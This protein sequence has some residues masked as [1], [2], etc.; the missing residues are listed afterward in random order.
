MGKLRRWIIGTVSGLA[1]GAAALLYRSCGG[2]GVVHSWKN[3]TESYALNTLVAREAARLSPDSQAGDADGDGIPNTFQDYITLVQRGK[4]NKNGS[5]QDDES[6]GD[7]FEDYCRQ[8]IG[9]VDESLVRLDIFSPV[10]GGRSDIS[11][12]VDE[13]VRQ[14][15][16]GANSSDNDVESMGQYGQKQPRLQPKTPGRSIGGRTLAGC[17]ED[18][19]CLRSLGVDDITGPDGKPDGVVDDVDTLIYA[20]GQ[21]CLI[22]TNGDNTPET[23]CEDLVGKYAQCQEQLRD[24]TRKSPTGSSPQLTSPRLTLDDCLGVPYQRTTIGKTLDECASTDKG[25]STSQSAAPECNDY[26]RV[27]RKSGIKPTCE[28]MYGALKECREL[29]VRQDQA[30]RSGTTGAQAQGLTSV[31]SQV[32]LSDACAGYGVGD[33]NG[34]GSSCDDLGLAYLSANDGPG[35]GSGSYQ[36]D[37]RDSRRTSS[38]VEQACARLIGAVSGNDRQGIRQEVAN[39]AAS[40]LPPDFEVDSG[41]E[42]IV[43]MAMDLDQ[44]FVNIC[45]PSQELA[46]YNEAR[47]GFRETAREIFSVREDGKYLNVVLKGR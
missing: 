44:L 31:N 1:L 32:D 10:V 6:E 18:L 29:A 37:A 2:D 3:K 22:D 5:Q 46:G 43:G 25:V 13:L 27:L 11:K 17:E 16:D 47:S 45:G 30:L 15:G 4:K 19:A 9:E 38:E 12:G 26:S 36:A 28:G 24:A 8:Q 35:N 14:C 21:E 20:V 33:A 40:L 7:S 34:D 39:Y 41:E 23:R 42:I